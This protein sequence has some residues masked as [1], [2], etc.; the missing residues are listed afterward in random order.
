[1]GWWTKLKRSKGARIVTGI[2]TG[3]ASEIVIRVDD[4]GNYGARFSDA[5]QEGANAFSRIVLRE[6]KEL[7]PDSFADALNIVKILA[8]GGASWGI[9]KAEGAFYDLL[10]RWIAPHL[11]E[12]GKRMGHAYA[13]GE[14]AVVSAAASAFDGIDNKK[15]RET[16][17]L[18][19]RNVAR[20]GYHLVFGYPPCVCERG[21]IKPVADALA[22]NG[23]PY[24]KI[25]GQVLKIVYPIVQGTVNDVPKFAHIS[26]A[27]YMYA[28]SKSASG[29][30]L[31][32][33]AK[34]D[35]K[36]LKVV[37]RIVDEMGK[38]KEFLSGMPTS[39]ELYQRYLVDIVARGYRGP[40]VMGVTNGYDA[41][42]YFENP[43]QAL[44]VIKSADKIG[45]VTKV[46]GK[47]LEY[48]AAAEELIQNA[49]EF[50]SKSFDM[51]E[52]VKNKDFDFDPKM[53]KE[54]ADK[55]VGA[56]V[57]EAEKRLKDA[58]TFLDA[59]TDK[60][61]RALKNRMTAGRS[62]RGVLRGINAFK[63]AKQD[64]AAAR[65]KFRSGSF[66][67]LG[68]SSMRSK[69]RSSVALALKNQSGV[70]GLGTTTP[71][72]FMGEWMV[73]EMGLEARAKWNAL[74]EQWLGLTA[75]QQDSWKSESKNSVPRWQKDATEWDE[76]AKIFSESAMAEMNL[77]AKM[78]G[79]S[80]EGFADSAYDMFL[81]GKKSAGTADKVAEAVGHR[82]GIGG[83]NKRLKAGLAAYR[84]S[85][86]DQGES[87]DRGTGRLAPPEVQIAEAR[88]GLNTASITGPLLIAAAIATGATALVIARRR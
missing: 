47:Y 58:D 84:A 48:V 65:S 45:D 27:L 56:A 67:R 20:E 51:Y 22:K 19:A 78:V 9:D 68:S 50:K 72:E 83:L 31:L 6:L 28:G 39:H 26:Q 16:M 62:Y 37:K 21:C 29:I 11:Q 7:K 15:F 63:E 52:A 53:I 32:P 77:A 2:A 30:P 85:L 87:L 38:G 33:K 34:F 36:A 25:V 18:I 46:V 10:S 74:A 75:A 3:G 86:K 8:T 81:R 57:D 35:K 66:F 49:K 79:Q 73:A 12:L 17:Q 14:Q 1:M 60:S 88:A 70:S 61:M 55:G 40:V 42:Y 4:L 13:N 71:E 44:K 54:Y 59:A 5:A 80:F 43:D 23:N 69:L 82:M 24:V 41:R 64:V 76:W